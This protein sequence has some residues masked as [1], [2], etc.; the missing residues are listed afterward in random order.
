MK[1]IFMRVRLLLKHRFDL[2]RNDRLKLSILQALPF[3]TASLLTGLVAVLYAKLFLWAEKLAATIFGWHE[4]M[5]FIQAPLF[6]LIGW[7]LVK[8]WSPYAKGS[9]IPQVMAAIDLA[10]PKQKHKIEKLLSLRVAAVKIVS[11]LS[12]VLG[13][14]AVGREGPTIQIAGS[15]FEFVNKIFP[16]TWPKVARANMIVG[17]AAAGLAAAFNTPLGGIVFAM[18]EL[19][20]NHISFYRTALFSAVIIAGLTAQTLLGPYLYL[21]YPNAESK[22]WY[23]LL[24]AILVAVLGGLAGSLMT[25]LILKILHWKASFPKTIHHIL[26]LLVCSLTL[27]GIAFFVSKEILGSGKETMVSLL[28]SDNKHTGGG[29][30]FLRFL[31]PLLSFTPGGAGGVFAPGLTAGA[32][33]GSSVADWFHLSS[34]ETNLIILAGMAAFLTGITRSPFTSAILVLEMTDRHSVIFYLILASM[35]AGLAAMFVDKKSFYDRLKHDYLA[36]FKKEE[37]AEQKAQ[38][39]NDELQMA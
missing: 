6:F 3:W 9:G 17:G 21:G 37:L 7:W 2:I 8:K 39:N 35:V 32:V 31:G 1:K 30:F 36:D 10:N 33:L 16:A 14:A 22:A 28:F 26:F 34:G 29:L 38:T 24:I 20:K 25:K 11:S 27:A 23:I 5:L 12:M 15:I 13:G 19:S 18:E 4:W